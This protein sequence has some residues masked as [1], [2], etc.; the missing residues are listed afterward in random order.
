[1]QNEINQTLHLDYFNNRKFRQSLH[2]SKILI[3][4]KKVYEH[5]NYTREKIQLPKLLWES[6]KTEN[7][8]NDDS[9]N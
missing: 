3:Y 6:I 9:G 1:M 8:L 5:L 2:F 4:I 7:H